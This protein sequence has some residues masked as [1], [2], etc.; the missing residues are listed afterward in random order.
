MKKLKDFN[1]C[2]HEWRLITTSLGWKDGQLFYCVK[3]LA[4]TKREIKAGDDI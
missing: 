3:C 2:E 4:S 1:T